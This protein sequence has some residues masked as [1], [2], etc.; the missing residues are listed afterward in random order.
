MKKVLDFCGGR[1]TCFA[2]LL[3]VF[4]TVFLFTGKCDFEQWS[5]FIIYIYGT[6]S[7]SNGV[8]H[9]AKGISR[10]EK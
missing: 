3:T 6:Y 10:K 2:L 8:E 7:V 9:V 4:V 5:S 1:K